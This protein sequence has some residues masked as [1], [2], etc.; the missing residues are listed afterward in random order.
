[1]VMESGLSCT[2]V[3]GSLDKRTLVSE[4]VAKGVEPCL[5]VT[6]AGSLGT[7]NL[8]V[9]RSGLQ[10]PGSTGGMLDWVGGCL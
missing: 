7:W 6:E 4:N 9:R 8:G 3:R 1:M 2:Q 10:D 5:G